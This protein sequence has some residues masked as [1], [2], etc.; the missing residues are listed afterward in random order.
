MVTKKLAC[1]AD[2]SVHIVL[3]RCFEVMDLRPSFSHIFIAFFKK[4]KIVH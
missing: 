4:K 3:L 2:W 1:L